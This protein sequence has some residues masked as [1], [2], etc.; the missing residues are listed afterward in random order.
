[1]SLIRIPARWL[2]DF[3]GHFPA[4]LQPGLFA[5]AVLLIAWLLLRRRRALW[6]RSVRCASISADVIVGLL[7]LPEYAWTS[8][9]RARGQAP[10]PLVQA[11]GRVSERVLD[12]A[13]SAYERHGPVPATGRPPLVW[14]AIFCLLSLGVHWLMLRTPSNGLTQFAGNIWVH[15]SSFDNWARRS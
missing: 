1:M 14:S 5:A 8:A 4:A 6:N 2:I 3:T 7:L 15:W 10:G 11:G 12:H 13:A 9:H